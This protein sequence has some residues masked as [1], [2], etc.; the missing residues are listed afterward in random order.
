MRG[1]HAFERQPIDE[2]YRWFASEAAPT[3]PTWERLCLWIADHPEVSARLDAL[4]GAKRQPNVFLGALKYLG[5]PLEA[6]PG[7]AE[8]VAGHWADLERVILTRATQTNEPGR[9][10]VLAPVLASL[11]QPITL[12]EVGSSAGLALIPDRYRYRYVP[13]PAGPAVAAAGFD[14]LSRRGGQAGGVDG[15]SQLGGAQPGTAGDGALAAEG[16]APGAPVLECRVGGVAPG[17]PAELRV[18]AR[19]GLDVNPLDPADAD[20]ARWLRALVWPGEDAR[21]ARLAAALGLAAADP[22]PILRGDLRHGLDA[23]LARVAPGTTPVLQHSAVLAYLPRDERDAFAAAVRTAGVHWLSYEGPSVVT[24][25][26]DRLTDREAWSG[27]PNFVVALD[28]KPIA[29]AS[30]HGGWVSWY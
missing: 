26:R 5:G 14:G 28:G 3:S 8:W 16:T 4:P 12:L 30:A 11:P 27:T 23:L 18:A 22:P 20:D 29:R 1:V 9:C 21:E 25:A 6:G 7:F 2:L 13:G 17:D 24:E 15:L 19:C 10:A